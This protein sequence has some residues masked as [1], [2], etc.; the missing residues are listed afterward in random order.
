M[1]KIS[2]GSNNIHQNGLYQSQ[3]AGQPHDL[4][5][6]STEG[7]LDTIYTDYTHTDIPPKLPDE[8]EKLEYIYIN[9]FKMMK[10]YMKPIH[11]LQQNKQLTFYTPRL[12]MILNK[13]CLKML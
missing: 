9:I 7:S 6:E 2:L 8:I 4:P 13:D 5:K 3:G 12:I 1:E 10:R 11:M